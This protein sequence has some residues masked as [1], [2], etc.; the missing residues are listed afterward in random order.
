MEIDITEKEWRTRYRPRDMYYNK[1]SAT[2]EELVRSVDP[3]LVWTEVH[4]SEDNS[5]YTYNGYTNNFEDV[6]WYICEIPWEGLPLEIFVEMED[7]GTPE[8]YMDEDE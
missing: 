4:E 2:D 5:L 6:G 3:H 8:E 7:D 1:G